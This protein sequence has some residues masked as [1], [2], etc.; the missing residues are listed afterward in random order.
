MLYCSVL[1]GTVLYYTVLCC[2]VLY[3]TV[4]FSTT[5]HRTV[6]YYTA[7]SGHYGDATDLLNAMLRSDVQNAVFYAIYDPA[8]VRKGRFPRDRVIALLHSC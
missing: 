6:L 8:A 3:C 1:Y 7:G 2:A 5:L 4:L